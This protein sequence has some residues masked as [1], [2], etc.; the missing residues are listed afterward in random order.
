MNFLISQSL[1]Q[2]LMLAFSLSLMDQTQAVPT[3]DTCPPFSV[4]VGC[5]KTCFYACDNLNQMSEA[6]ILPCWFGCD[7][8]EGY[9]YESKDSKVCVPISQC[10][11]SCPEHS[12]FNP[13][14]KTYRQSCY[15]LGEKPHASE[16]CLPRCVCDEGYVLNEGECIKISECPPT[17]S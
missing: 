12:T 3:A 8:K 16:K 9:V 13:C 6:C 15:T 2:L 11:V 10:K 14:L 7:C 1:V 5:R 17:S 4:E